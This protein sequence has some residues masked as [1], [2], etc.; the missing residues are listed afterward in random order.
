MITSALQ[1]SLL[2]GLRAIRR[3]MSSMKAPQQCSAETRLG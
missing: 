2:H 1:E 3:G